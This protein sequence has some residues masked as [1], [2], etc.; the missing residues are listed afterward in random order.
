MKFFLGISILITVLIPSFVSCNQESNKPNFVVNW[1]F[2]ESDTILYQSGKIRQINYKT[3]LLDEDD[4]IIKNQKDQSE[5]IDKQEVLQFNYGAKKTIELHFDSI[6]NPTE[7]NYYSG[8]V[9]VDIVY[10][11]Y[12][13]SQINQLDSSI[14]I[15]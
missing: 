13:I 11:D 10:G 3:A 2:I 4:V 8:K 12:S 1:K 15:E 6:G 14:V 9:E 5:L 7:I